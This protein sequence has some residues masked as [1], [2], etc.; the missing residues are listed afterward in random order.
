MILRRTAVRLYKTKSPH[1]P[2]NQR[3]CQIELDNLRIKK[4]PLE[5]RFPINNNVNF[6]FL[7]SFNL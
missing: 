5:F 2:L 1:R 6:I 7:H 4:Q 3:L